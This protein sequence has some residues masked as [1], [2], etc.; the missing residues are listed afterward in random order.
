MS[1]TENLQQQQGRLYKQ[2]IETQMCPNVMKQYQETVKSLVDDL[3]ENADCREVD[4]LTFMTYDEIHLDENGFRC[5]ESV[6]YRDVIDQLGMESILEEDLGDT[7]DLEEWLDIPMDN[8]LGA[9]ITAELK[10]L[11]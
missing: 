8:S 7:S 5:E 6:S 4:I 3:G 9:Q 10:A 2:L 1:A 11:S